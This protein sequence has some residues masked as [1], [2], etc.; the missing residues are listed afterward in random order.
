MVHKAAHPTWGT[1]EGQVLPR[2]Q[3][4]HA[5]VSDLWT[6]SAVALLSLF[7]LG[8][9]RTSSC[10]S[11]VQFPDLSTTLITHYWKSFYVS[12]F[13]LK[14]ALQDQIIISHDMDTEF[15]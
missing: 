2:G 14:H 9:H 10:A 8:L 11:N 7:P 15:L 6:S 13:V 4:L 1:S 12:H 3:S 5:L